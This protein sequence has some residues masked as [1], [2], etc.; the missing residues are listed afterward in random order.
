M[1][2]WMTYLEIVSRMYGGA[3]IGRRNRTHHA[4]ELQP[5][6]SV[7]FTHT[8]KTTYERTAAL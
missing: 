8:N 7:Q 6:A 4:Y 2:L 5:F 1:Q 3:A